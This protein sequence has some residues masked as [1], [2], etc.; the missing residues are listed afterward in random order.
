MINKILNKKKTLTIKNFKQTIINIS[1]RY[2][3]KFLKIY[4]HNFK[5]KYKLI[6]LHI[7]FFN[8]KIKTHS[9]NVSK[10]KRLPFLLFLPTHSY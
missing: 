2:K 3:I 4:I 7:R 1:L 10:N 9:S 5:I 8:I 6:F